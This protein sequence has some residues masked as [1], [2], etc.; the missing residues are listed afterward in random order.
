MSRLFW[1]YVDLADC[2]PSYEAMLIEFSI[3][4]NF[5]HVTCGKT[6][7]TGCIPAAGFNLGVGTSSTTSVDVCNFY[8]CVAEGVSAEG[9]LLTN[10]FSC[11]FYG[12]TSE[13]NGRG[14]QIEA[15]SAFNTFD[16][17]FCESNSSS[18]FIVYGHHNSFIQCTAT[19]PNSMVMSG[20]ANIV[21]GGDYD[22]INGGA[23]TRNVFDGV[24]CRTSFTPGATDKYRNIKVA[25]AYI[26]DHW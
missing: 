11:G 24:N 22:S 8:G 5:Y 7:S 10:A 17:M 15:N 18:D 6:F 1:S 21:I 19:S 3:L 25:G 2:N 9:F 12:G 16:R 26:A 23:G 20:E 13:S 4:S 14:V